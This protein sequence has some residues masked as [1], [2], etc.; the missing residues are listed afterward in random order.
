V[1]LFHGGVAHA[2][3]GF[4]GVEVFF[5]LSGFLITSL[6]VAE[7]RDTG[8]IALRDFWSRRA[9]RLLPALFLLVLVIG[10]FY[11]AAGPS[12]A[13]PGFLSDGIS[14]LLYYSNWHQ[15]AV[16]T[17]YFVASGPISPFQHTWSL[18]IEEQFYGVWPLLLLGVLW[19]AG[20]RSPR[21]P[22]AGRLRL[23]L[24]LTLIGLLGSAVDA[25]WL[26]DGGRGLDRVYYGTDTRATG[27]LAGA[28]LAFA[29]A[30]RQLM[31]ARRPEAVRAPAWR[32]TVERR[33]DRDSFWLLLL[34]IIGLEL[35]SGSAGWLYPWGMLV[36][37]A[38]VVAL[39]AG[40][41]LRPEAAATRML[42]VG[43]LQF[44]GR[45][46]YGLYLW[47]FPLFLWLDD[48]A[49]GL[50]GLPLLLL[51]LAVTFAVSIASY[52][53][54]EQPIR[55]RRVPL[56]A[57][58][59]LAPLGAAA[60]TAALFI[61]ATNSSLPTGVPAAA[62]LPAPSPTLVGSDPACTVQ[63]T[64]TPDVGTAPV[65]P[66]IEASFEYKSLGQRRLTWSGSAAKTFHTCPP[67]RVLF[68]GDSIAFT[69]GTPMLSDEERYGTEVANAAILGCA[70]GT[71]GELNV[72]GSWKLPAEGCPDE[73]ARWTAAEQSFH[74]DEVVVE[75]GYRDEFDW[76][77]DGQIVHL[78]MPAY[79]AYVEQQ[80]NG[81]ISA[82]GA[83]GTKILFLSVPFTHPPDQ[84]NGAPAPAASPARHARI[85]A[86]LQ[87]AAAAH[88]GQV[89]VLDLDATISPG[90]H[91]DA[92]VNGQVCRFDGIHFTVFCAKLLEPGILTTARSLLTSR[93]RPGA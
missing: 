62:K 3:G 52:V 13:V 34:V 4:L 18:A 1:L 5:V 74:P 26:F 72:N 78:G 43:P 55:Q 93:P 22:V 44:V 85:N 14:A 9:R 40:V 71:R 51:R 17:S 82:L 38:V 90:G 16:G 68:V 19:L 84:S 20:R 39:I 58:R 2:R 30:L 8:A 61:G 37:D 60:A 79:D 54:L 41:A 73:M 53:V 76:L 88:P 56:P 75:L 29:M 83:G 15:I 32:R 23:L 25:A 21:A 86:L 42:S 81:L 47:H 92:R 64:D 49:T 33:F 36:L 45:I 46:S 57:V 11:A 87:E 91:Y 77:W 63:L 89:S 6:L 28:A 67:K 59:R 66:G 80:I 27:L 69:I 10:L 24:A 48:A 31:A 70:F 35:A 50:G 12:L 7:W 65:P